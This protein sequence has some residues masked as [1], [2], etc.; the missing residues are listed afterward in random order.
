MRCIRAIAGVTLL[1]IGSIP[2]GFSRADLNGAPLPH[3]Q[4][5]PDKC[6]PGPG[7]PRLACLHT[8]S[9]RRRHVGSRAL[10]RT[11]PALIAPHDFRVVISS[12]LRVTA[13]QAVSKH[14]QASRL[15][16]AKWPGM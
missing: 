7:D 9:R 5:N 14:M 4:P 2:I 11:V 6:V 10:Q 1:L 16:L 8:K 15:A 12:I 13:A 3:A